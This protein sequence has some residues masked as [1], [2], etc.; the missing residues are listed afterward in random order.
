MITFIFHDALYSSQNSFDWHF[1]HTVQ[2]HKLLQSIHRCH[3]R[4]EYLTQAT[5]IFSFNKTLD[6]LHYPIWTVNLS[7]GNQIPVFNFCIGHSYENK[8]PK[9]SHWWQVLLS[10]VFAHCYKPFQISI[11]IKTNAYVCYEIGSKS[12]KQSL[13]RCSG[14]FF[15][16]G[17]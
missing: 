8:S 4:T 6:Q 16:R 9:D 14:F 10:F 13:V 5:D 17:F 7:L 2:W 11:K 1:V 12:I 3:S 15:C